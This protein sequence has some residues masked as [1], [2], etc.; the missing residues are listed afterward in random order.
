MGFLGVCRL[1]DSEDQNLAIHADELSDIFVLFKKHHA[2][3]LSKT[4]HSTN[5]GFVIP[6]TRKA[7]ELRSYG[8]GPFVP[9]VNQKIT[10]HDANDYR[11]FQRLALTLPDY[12]GTVLLWPYQ[13]EDTLVLTEVQVM[14]SEQKQAD[15][16]AAIEAKRQSRAVSRSDNTDNLRQDAF[17]RR[18]HHL[19]FPRPEDVDSHTEDYL[20]GLIEFVIDERAREDGAYGRSESNFVRKQAG[21]DG[22]EHAMDRSPMNDRRSNMVP[23]VLAWTKVNLNTILLSFAGVGVGIIIVV[24][25]MLTISSLSGE[26]ETDIIPHV[27]EN[28][29][30]TVE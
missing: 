8:D 26:T 21:K 25:L 22:F 5:I 19:R 10:T 27:S 7:A 17:F 29:P 6:D 16:R 13:A 2:T 30:D 14:L 12:A 11:L 15:Y 18:S 24:V 20:I 3:V 1:L 9:C 23:R 28:V 4:R